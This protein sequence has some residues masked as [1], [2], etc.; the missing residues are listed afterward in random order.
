MTKV[1]T[2][3]ELFQATSREIVRNKSRIEKFAFQ[4]RQNSFWLCGLV[5]IASIWLWNWKLLL[6]TVAGICCMLLAFWMQNH[7]WQQYWTKWRRFLTGFNRK[8]VV[9]V[10]SGSIGAFGTYLAACIWADAENH[11]LAV[12][13]ILQGCSSLIALLLLVWA[14]VRRQKP[15]IESKLE[16][17]QGDLTHSDSLKRLIAIRQLTRMLQSKHLPCEYSRQC[18]EYFGLMLG[19]PQVPVVRQA[20]IDSLEQL[21]IQNISQESKTL[22]LPLRL[23]KQ[24]TKQLM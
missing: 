13:S 15:Y 3:W 2:W 11:W 20:L 8:L 19:Q 21:K 23:F 24:Y 18:S 14:M 7:C 22:Q 4:Q 10:G 5:A 12:G 16:K 6:A 1:L 9:A 17:L